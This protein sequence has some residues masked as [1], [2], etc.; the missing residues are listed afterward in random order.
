MKRTIL[1]MAVAVLTAVTG[2]A[3]PVNPQQAPQMRDIYPDEEGLLYYYDSETQEAVL[4]DPSDLMSEAYPNTVLTVHPS[5]TLKGKGM[6]GNAYDKIILI[7]EIGEKAFYGAAASS[8]VF[9]EGSNVRAIRKQAF[10]SMPNMNGVLVLPASLQELDLSAICLP[11]ITG[12]TFLGS[13]PPACATGSG[14]A[15]NPWTSADGSTPADIKVTVPAGC[16]GVYRAKA[17]LGDYF[18]NISEVSAEAT[19]LD[20]IEVDEAGA[21]KMLHAGRMVIVRGGLTFDLMGTMLR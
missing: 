2:W 8:V 3:A 12:I 15:S 17:G 7:V 14:S 13:V 19:A 18:S 4:M 10:A 16:Y 21:V 1:I 6:S 11:G 20:V 5:F 9:E